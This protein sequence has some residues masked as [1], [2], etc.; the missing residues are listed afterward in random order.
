MFKVWTKNLGRV[1][2]SEAHV[3]FLALTCS[4][5]EQL[6]KPFLL[7]GNF[8]TLKIHADILAIVQSKITV[9]VK[10]RNMF[11]P[12][13]NGGLLASLNQFHSK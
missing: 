11:C 1:G 4:D 12:T 2:K 5:A 9:P 3:Y 13:A 8:I 10:I 6:G 7:K